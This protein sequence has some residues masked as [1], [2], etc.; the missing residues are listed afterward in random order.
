M[1]AVGPRALNAALQAAARNKK[2][3]VVNARC[4]RPLDEE[5]LNKIAR[6]AIV[7]MEENVLSGGFG[8]QVLA[9]YAA[10]GERVKIRNLAFKEGNVK[11]AGVSSQL[12]TG[13]L[14]AEDV[15][16]AAARF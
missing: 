11:H 10:R 13:G 16:N 5:I 15:L 4:V 12:R 3:C 9:Y 7:T 8:E 6:R 14:T 1:L 2:I